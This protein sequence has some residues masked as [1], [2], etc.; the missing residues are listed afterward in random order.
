LVHA[1][2]RA[3]REVE[4]R[5]AAGACIQAGRR[6]DMLWRPR[7]AQPAV[8]HS[9]EFLEAYA[10]RRGVGPDAA[11][12][13]ATP[14]RAK[15]GSCTRP[16]DS[17]ERSGRVPARAGGGSFPTNVAGGLE[18]TSCGTQGPFVPA[19]RRARGRSAVGPRSTSADPNR[20]RP[21]PRST[22]TA[23]RA[24]CPTKSTSHQ[25]KKSTH[26]GQQRWSSWSC[27]CN[28]LPGGRGM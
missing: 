2:G 22:P 3:G 20:A 8:Q 12:A 7:S 19:R 9:S 14:G 6:G 11:I 28:R 4:A 5:E 27:S 18:N 15:G 10:A 17:D 24:P 26:D 23:R 25:I 13:A 1:E 16:G 21:Q